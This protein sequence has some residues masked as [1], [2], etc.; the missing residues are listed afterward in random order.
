[1]KNRQELYICA[2]LGIMGL[3]GPVFPDIFVI[4]AVLRRRGYY[5]IF[6]K[7]RIPYWVRLELKPFH[8][9]RQGNH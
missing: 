4:I 6:I 7:G 1:M 2:R 9:A 3:G 8:Y 5:F